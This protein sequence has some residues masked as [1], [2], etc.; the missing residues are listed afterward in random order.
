MKLIEHFH[1]CIEI[2]ARRPAAIKI[3]PSIVL[4]LTG[5]YNYNFPSDGTQ[6]LLADVEKQLIVGALAGSHDGCKSASTH[7][8]L[9]SCSSKSVSSG[10]DCACISSSV[11]QGGGH[12]V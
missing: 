7:G 6:L 12:L 4:A 10:L 11:L 2:K 1:L 8:A 9:Y 3:C 5:R